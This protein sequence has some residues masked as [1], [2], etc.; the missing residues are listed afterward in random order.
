MATLTIPEQDRT[1]TDPSEISEYLSTMGIWYRRFEAGTE[2]PAEASAEEVLA[3]FAEPIET[4]KEEGGYGTAD[5]IHITPELEG[6]ETM[7]AKFDKEHWHSEDEVRFIVEGQGL[8]HLRGEDGPV[9]RLQ[10]VAG[11]MINVP[12]STKHWF[13]LCDDRRIRAI[14]LF[15]DPAGWVANYTDS[16]QEKNFAPLCFGPAYL[17]GEAPLEGP[18]DV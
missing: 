8:F 12:A 9:V 6:L 5:V 18:L 11:D 3:A 13:H 2:I 7:L 14:R 10:V 1:L 4:L 16:G 17:Q 15:Q